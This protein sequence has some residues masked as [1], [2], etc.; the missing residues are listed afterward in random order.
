MTSI[1]QDLRYGVRVLWKSP[2]FTVTAILALALGIGANTAIFSVVN[3]ILLQPL[4]YEKPEQ[5]VRIGSA[6]ARTGD[7]MGSFSP[8]DF[9]D[10][11]ARNT[12]FESIAAYDGWSPSLTG[13]GEPEKIEA[14]RVSA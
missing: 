3:A 1:L 4:P 13:V 11:R 8:Q 14:G 9:Y 5:L 10:W 7:V 6:N 12:V 2:G